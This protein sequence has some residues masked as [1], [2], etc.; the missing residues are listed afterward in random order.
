ALFHGVAGTHCTECNGNG[1]GEKYFFHRFL[2]F[3]KRWQ[4][5]WE[6]SSEK[7]TRVFVFYRQISEKADTLTKSKCRFG[8]G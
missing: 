2:S 7:K 6:Q 3:Q 5:I 1:K 4:T 8:S